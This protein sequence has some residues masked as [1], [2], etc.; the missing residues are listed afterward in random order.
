MKAQYVG[1][2]GDFGKVLILKHLADLGFRLGIHWM[3]TANVDRADGK[4]RAYAGYFGGDCLCC[5]DD[6]VFERILPLARMSKDDRSI[7]DLKELIRHFCGEVGFFS[8][9]YSNSRSHS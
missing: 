1:D 4:H 9:E 3:L 6:E 7:A 8:S 5:C 2:I